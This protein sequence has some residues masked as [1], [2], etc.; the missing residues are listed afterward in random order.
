MFAMVKGV[1][2]AYLL[3]Y[4]VVKGKVHVYMEKLNN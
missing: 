3:K 2:M 1:P 4:E